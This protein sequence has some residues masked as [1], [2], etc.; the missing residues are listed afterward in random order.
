VPVE[1]IDTAGLRESLDEAESLGIAK[2]REAMAEA[3]VVL[4]VLD[5]TEPLH[6]ED[7]AT[8]ATLAGR[9]FLIVINKN[10]LAHAALPGPRAFAALQTS[11]LTGAGVHELRRAILSLLTIEPLGAETALLTNLRQQQAVSAALSALIQAQQAVIGTI[12][13]EMIL[14]DLYEA[15]HALDALTGATTSDDILD[16]IFSKFCIGK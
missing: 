11:A 12:P 15:L 10:D 5:A 6:K 9:T 14:L 3:D 16:L 2:S 13:H 4:L 8:I 1:L 7:E